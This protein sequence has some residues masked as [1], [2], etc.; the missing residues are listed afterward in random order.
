[1]DVT[2]SKVS[3]VILLGIIKFCFGIAPLAIR[4]KLK[5]E[6]GGGKWL[7]RFIGKL[8]FFD[9]IYSKT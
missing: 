1:M 6:N 3:V 4:G 8:I 7:N 9:S 2:A 5:R